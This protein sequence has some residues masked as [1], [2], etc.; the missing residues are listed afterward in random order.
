MK[1]TKILQEVLSEIGDASK[2]PYPFTKTGETGE[3][4]RYQFKTHV[5]MDPEDG[6][7]GPTY[8]VTVWNMDQG[9]NEPPTA[10][11]SFGVLD[12][13]NEVEYDESTNRGDLY[14]VMSTIA[15]I[16]KQ[17]IDISGANRIHFSPSKRPGKFKDKDPKSNV[18]TQL[19]AKYIKSYWPKATVSTTSRKTILVSL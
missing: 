18:R 9:P 11:V 2:E 1:L 7:E 6:L 8:E 16:V 13:D 17:D 3:T 12:K 15:A 4:R 14:K 5:G 10:D 19:Y